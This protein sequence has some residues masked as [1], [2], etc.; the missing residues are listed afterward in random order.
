MIDT[1]RPG[2]LKRA[3]PGD[4]ARLIEHI[5]ETEGFESPPL[6]PMDPDAVDAPAAA[7]VPDRETLPRYRVAYILGVA[8]ERVDAWI[9]D[10]LLRTVRGDS[11][12]SVRIAPSDL[13]AFLAAHPG[14]LDWRTVERG[15]WQDAVRLRHLRDPH[16]SPK[17]AAL[18]LGVALATLYAWLRDGLVPG[19]YHP[20]GTRRAWRIPVAALDALREQRQA[21]AS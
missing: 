1:T 10:G 15:P 14:L 3:K 21:R 13:E 20:H 19:A 18:R 17:Q 11:R 2:W 8:H 16:L 6:P 4:I 7:P 9:A 5:R 12:S